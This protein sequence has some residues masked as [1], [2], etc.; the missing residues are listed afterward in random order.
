[1][2]IL[3]RLDNQVKHMGYRIE[4][5]EIEI[6][7]TQLKYVNQACCVYNVINNLSVLTLFVS[8]NQKELKVIR[9]DIKNLIPKYM[10]PSK[11]HTIDKL[12]LNSNGKVDRKALSLKAQNL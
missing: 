5:E 4:L 1:M 9:D 12:P 2:Y 6:C 10:I 3:G 11:I 7:V 8:T